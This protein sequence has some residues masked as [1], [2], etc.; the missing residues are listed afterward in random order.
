MKELTRF[1]EREVPGQAGE[2]MERL[3]GTEN[4]RGSRGGEDE[5]MKVGVRVNAFGTFHSLNFTSY[6]S[7]FDSHSLQQY[8]FLFNNVL[9]Y[10]IISAELQTISL[11]Y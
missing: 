5:A 3:I 8:T 1:Y 7:Y 11:P 10:E 6:M 4:G 9:S 2:S